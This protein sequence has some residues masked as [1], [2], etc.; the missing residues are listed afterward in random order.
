MPESRSQESF[1]ANLVAKPVFLDQ[2]T[3]AQK[4]DP[5]LSKLKGKPKRQCYDIQE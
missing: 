1:M 3:K 2:I 5:T 4:E